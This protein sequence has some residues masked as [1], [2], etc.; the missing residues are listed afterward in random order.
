MDYKGKVISKVMLTSNVFQLTIKVNG[1]IDY[2]IGQ[3]VNLY[4]PNK[5]LPRPISIAGGDGE[6]LTFLIKIVGEGTRYLGG[7]ARGDEVKLVGPLGK[8]FTVEGTGNKKV[9][10]V[11]GGIGIAPL[12]PLTGVKFKEVKYYFGFKEKAYALENIAKEYPLTVTLDKDGQNIVDIFA[13]DLERESFDFVYFCGPQIMLKKLQNILLKKG[14]KGE[15]STEAKMAC[16]VG[17]CLV[18]TCATVDGY[19]RVCKDGPVFSVG[20]VV[21]DD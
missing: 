12:L 10:I 13:K 1:K 8:G 7:L 20:E 21:F 11:G 3:F 14:I 2:K 18:C 19:K 4:C 15:L 17:G 5:I 16:G 6:Y 9:A